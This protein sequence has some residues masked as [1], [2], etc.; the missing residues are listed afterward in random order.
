MKR[1]ITVNIFGSLYRM[2]EDAYAVLN[3]Y[4][5]N[6]REHFSRQPDG[7]EIAD[8]IEGRA[9]ELMSELTASGVEAISIEHVDEIIRRI[10]NPEELNCEDSIDEDHMTP[11]DLPS[12]DDVEDGPVTRRLFRDPSHRI[13]AGVCSGIGSYFSVNPLWIRLLFI[14]LLIPSLGIAAAL[15]II[16]WICIPLASTPAERLQ[17]KGEPVNMANLCKE[18]L[19]STREM[20]NRGGDLTLDNDFK[21]GAFTAMK[22]TGYTLGILLAGFCSLIL[23]GAI[24]SLICAVSAP[25]GDMREFMGEGNPIIMILDSNP[26]WLVATACASA[27]ILLI[28]TLHAVVHFT[29]HMMDKVGPMS[30]QLRVACV[31]VW[32]LALIVFLIAATNIVSNVNIKYTRPNRETWE[33]R[34]RERKEREA[35]RQAA[36]LADGGWTLTHSKGLNGITF[37]SG[38]HFSGNDRTRYLD[39]C[40]DGDGDWMEYEV[41]RRL[42]V[43]PGTYTLKAAARANGSG[44]ELFATDG[45]QRRY[46]AD[47]PACGNKGG[48]IWNDARLALETDSLKRRP[49]RDYLKKM[50]HAND[51]K[52]YGWSEISIEGITVGA[53]SVLIYGVTTVSPEH[54]WE[55]TWLSA[56]SFELEK[57]K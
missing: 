1:N 51:K 54:T 14:V 26:I 46:T 47:I 25:W 40:K 23:I 53:D 9:A 32:V 31:A 18:F 55:G 21:R 35:I 22:W 49:D 19:G 5:L 7:K 4:I 37:R 16:F 17:M 24:I 41:T 33:R 11:P 13:I 45:K 36:Y 8:D 56:T 29:L 50:V 15:Y 10:G 12:N 38:E 3:T 2:D 43:A 42:K 27:L 39:A 20:L 30:R 52:G 34:Q 6:M 28:L 48:S 57:K 44:A